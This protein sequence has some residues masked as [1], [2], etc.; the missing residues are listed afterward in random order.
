M[1]S[2]KNTTNNKPFC[3]FCYNLGKPVDVY[4]SHY[5]RE[6]PAAN[7]RVV[8]PELRKCVCTGCGKCGHTVSRCSK[9]KKES[10]MGENIR[11]GIDAPYKNRHVSKRVEVLIQPKNIYDCLDDEDSDSDGETES[12]SVGSVSSSVITENE[13][14]MKSYA[15][16]LMSVLKP[17]L[18]PKSVVVYDND[19][20]NEPKPKYDFTIF[21]NVKRYASWADADSS[22]DEA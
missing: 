1:A 14:S 8:C 13:V 7:S 18:E 12:V 21:K 17:E 15:A 19:S 2:V 4:T 6:T 20:E 22:D 10:R 11:H 5:V 9:Y 16:A 3:S